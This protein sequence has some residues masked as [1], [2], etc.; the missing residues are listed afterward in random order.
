MKQLM[1]MLYVLGFIGLPWFFGWLAVGRDYDPD[2][3]ILQWL[4]GWL[5]ILAIGFFGGLFYAG[6][7]GI[8]GE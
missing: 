1:V 2:P 3:I 7:A 8:L 5:V 4:F 6:L